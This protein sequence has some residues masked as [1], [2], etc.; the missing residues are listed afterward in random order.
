[1]SVSEDFR[2]ERLERMEAGE[3]VIDIPKRLTRLAAAVSEINR[4]IAE[5]NARLP[6]GTRRISSIA[7]QPGPDNRHVVRAA[8]WRVEEL[9][10]LITGFQWSLWSIEWRLKDLGWRLHAS[11]GS[12]SGAEGKELDISV[13]ELQVSI[14]DVETKGRE[15]DAKPTLKQYLEANI[16]KVVLGMGAAIIATVL[17]TELF[18]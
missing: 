15:I 7:W 9:D 10:R 6:E 3:G 4:Q 17:A 18:G 8:K 13:R 1:M 12:L 2:L 14:R 11:G 5:T 16:V